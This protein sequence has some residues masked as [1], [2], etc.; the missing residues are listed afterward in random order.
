MRTCADEWETEMSRR[1]SFGGK[2]PEK[3]AAEMDQR[4]KVRFMPKCGK[5]G[6]E[7]PRDQAGEKRNE[8]VLEALKAKIDAA[9]AARNQAAMQSQLEREAASRVREQREAAE[10]ERV[11]KARTCDY[12]RKSIAEARASID[13]INPAVRDAYRRDIEAAE[14]DFRKNCG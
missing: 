13:K 8:K 1:G 3:L 7:W 10:R 6:F 12:Q 11:A 5:Y 4:A 9:A 14:Q 2:L